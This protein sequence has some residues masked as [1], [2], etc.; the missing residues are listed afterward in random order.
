M[1][2]SPLIHKVRLPT[3]AVV[4][5]ESKIGITANTDNVS[6]IKRVIKEYY[7]KW[8]NNTLDFN[9]DRNVIERF[10]RKRLTKKL[11]EVFDKMQMMN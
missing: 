4:V 11:A 7:D 3:F 2:T 9:P 6:E 5:K 1:D 10:E 8:C